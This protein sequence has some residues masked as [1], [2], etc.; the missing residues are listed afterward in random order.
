LKRHRAMPIREF[1][2]GKSF[3]PETLAILNE[4][5]QG[6]CLDLGVTDQT[7]HSR[8]NVAKTVLQFADGQRDPR[9][10]RAAVVKFLKAR[11]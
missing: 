7:P 11:H 3:D 5:F 2:A 8:T 9:L 1:L 6:A 10:I 4:A